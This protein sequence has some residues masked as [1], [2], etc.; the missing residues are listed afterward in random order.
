MRRISAWM[1]DAVSNP[2]QHLPPGRDRCEP[3]VD[4]ATHRFRNACFAEECRSQLELSRRGIGSECARDDFGDV[5]HGAGARSIRLDLI[6][7]ARAPQE[8]FCLRRARFLPR[9]QL[10]RDPREHRGRG[11]VPALAEGKAGVRMKRISV[12]APFHQVAGRARS[13]LGLLSSQQCAPRDN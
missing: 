5:L 4:P 6:G 12:V 9:I 8:C 7:Q 10:D 11:Q 2:E 3:R 1:V 13:L